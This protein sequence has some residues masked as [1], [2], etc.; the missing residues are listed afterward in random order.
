MLPVLSLRRGQHSI[1]RPGMGPAG[2]FHDS[3]ITRDIGDRDRAHGHHH[4]ESRAQGALPAASGDCSLDVSVMG[5]RFGHW[6]DRVL[7]AV[8]VVPS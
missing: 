8:S 4:A 2:V 1:S 7:H 3:D 6:R 5:I